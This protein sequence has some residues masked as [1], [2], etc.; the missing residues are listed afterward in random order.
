MQP[1]SSLTEAATGATIDRNTPIFHDRNKF[2]YEE[3]TLQVPFG[4]FSILEELKA[5]NVKPIEAIVTL[6][7][8]YRSNWTSGL[9][10]KTST[11]TLA[12]VIGISHRY[13]RD[14]LN[15]AAHWVRRQ[16]PAEANIA[17]TW[18]VTHH[19]CSDDEV[20][21]DRDGHPQM[22]AVPRGEGGPF[23]RM[24]AGD[25]S[26]KGCLIWLLLKLHSDW[27][28]KNGITNPINMD[29]LRKW[30]GFSKSSV[31]A[32]IKELQEAGMLERLSQRWERSVFQL[33]P[34]PRTEPRAVRRRK[35]RA[36]KKADKNATREMRADGN[37]RFS[38]NEKYR[39]DVTTGDIDVRE[40][41]G[42]GLWKRASDYHI[43]QVMYPS[44]REAFSQAVEAHQAVQDYL[45]RSDARREAETKPIAQ[46]LGSLDNA[47]GS[48]HNAQG[49]IDS[50]HPIGDKYHQGKPPL[51]F[52]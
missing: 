32:I 6:T 17:G 35:K 13:V 21:T 39:V 1:F 45:K 36:A 30:T 31:I 47:Q 3:T 48:S 8:G 27:E 7:L 29:T 37:Y 23:E 4:E 44:I 9:T 16:T 52:S 15:R 46:T 24:F 14:G 26:W 22:F 43:A 38:F 19:L 41:Y 50:A 11:R 49:S 12:K 51:P 34:K 33:Y 18:Q 42:R 2:E 20:P 40:G 5:G 10:W 25:I 28:A